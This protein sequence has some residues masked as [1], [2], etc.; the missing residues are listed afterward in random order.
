MAEMQLNHNRYIADLEAVTVAIPDYDRNLV[1]QVLLHLEN[2][3]RCPACCRE[4]VSQ[5]FPEAESF[6]RYR[7]AELMRELHPNDTW[8]WRAIVTHPNVWTRICGSVLSKLVFRRPPN[9]HD[10]AR[11]FLAQMMA[12]HEL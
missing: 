5:S 2:W 1:G 8:L 11:T 7:F 6:F 12:E 4:A 9:A 3:T 10:K